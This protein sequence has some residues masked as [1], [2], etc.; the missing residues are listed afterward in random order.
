MNELQQQDINL[1]KESLQKI[2]KKLPNWQAPGRD[3]LQGYWIQACRSLHGDMERLLN[4]CLGDGWVPSWMSQGRTVLIQKDFR[5]GD[6]S[7][8]YRPITCLSIMWEILTG[9]IADC[10]YESLD[11]RGL[12]TAKQ[13]GCKHGTRG[14]HD[15]IYI[16]KMVLRE[17]KRRRKNLAVC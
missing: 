4:K 2:L 3:C 14:T 12:L 17:V 13:K 16:D 11:S 1:T 10:I 6:V 5:K 7:I 15:L 9:A 8:N